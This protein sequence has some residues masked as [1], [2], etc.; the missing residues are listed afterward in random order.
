MGE[1]R[2]RSIAVSVK[3][4]KNNSNKK[5][6]TSGFETLRILL[7]IIHMVQMTSWH[8]LH[9]TCAYVPPSSTCGGT[10][11]YSTS[12]NNHLV[13]MMQASAIFGM[14]CCSVLVL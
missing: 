6:L 1:T 9:S 5:R 12:S 11:N 13:S 8:C 10:Q 14:Q 3:M 7:W 4:F 2:D